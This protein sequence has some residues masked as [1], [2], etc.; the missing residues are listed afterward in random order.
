[1]CC[2]FQPLG[3][4]SHIGLE[5]QRDSARERSELMVVKG[6]WE[7]WLA[8]L[9]GFG[10]PGPHTLFSVGFCSCRPLW[11][12]RVSQLSTCVREWGQPESLVLFGG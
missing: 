1:M 2:E 11:L 4:A 8:S 12:R 7:P 9:G 10:F 6:L 5:T 3:L